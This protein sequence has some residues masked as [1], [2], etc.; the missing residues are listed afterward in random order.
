MNVL[1]WGSRQGLTEKF[2]FVWLL[3]FLLVVKYIN[4]FVVLQMLFFMVFIV[5]SRIFLLLLCSVFFGCGC[6]SGWY[7]CFHW[8]CDHPRHPFHIAWS[9]TIWNCVAP[10][11]QDVIMPRRWLSPRA[12]IPD[13]CIHTWW[14]R[15]K[16][17]LRR[18]SYVLGFMPHVFRRVFS[19]KRV[20]LC[21]L[22]H[23]SRK[24]KKIQNKKK[25]WE[26]RMK[27]NL[28]ISVVVEQGLES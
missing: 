26:Y 17:L 12:V 3:F 25:K 2:L 18:A 5:F 28:Y 6:S 24:A 10:F 9:E 15:I 20:A 4:C 23:A 11:V 14:L 22:Q 19:V 7:D 27:R 16:Q 13:A 21:F 8:W 1:W